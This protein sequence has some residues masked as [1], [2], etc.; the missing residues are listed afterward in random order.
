VRIDNG[1]KVTEEVESGMMLFSES[2]F[3]ISHQEKRSNEKDFLTS[4][5]SGIVVIL[6]TKKRENR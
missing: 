2:M 1:C 3:F 4:G 6:P 5:D